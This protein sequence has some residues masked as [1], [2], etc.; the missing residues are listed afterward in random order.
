MLLVC[1]LSLSST[2]GA[3]KVSELVERAKAFAL[4]AHKGQKRLNREETPLATHLEEV[5]SLVEWSG[6]NE[7]EIAAAWLH[8]V[9]ED[10]PVTLAEVA[11]NFG[12]EVASIV[13]GLT[14]P[15][16][17]K[18][19]H[20]L[21]RKI[22]QAARIYTEIDSVKR[23]KLADQISNVRSVVVDPPIRWDAQKCLD[24]VRGAEMIAWEC[25]D[26]SGCLYGKFLNAYND[27][28]KIYGDGFR[29]TA[30]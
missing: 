29:P 6:G 22:A 8:D 20:T 16:E 2:V 19:L 1:L 14:D 23:V 28:I 15:P 30:G 17:F 7:T 10:T 5:V 11:A 25:K 3:R 9:V 4:E 27:A 21:E 18:N 13:D 12:N 26:A 24:Y